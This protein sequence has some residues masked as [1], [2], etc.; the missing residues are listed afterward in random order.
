MQ[1]KTQDTE[2]L[3]L[4]PTFHS[5]MQILPDVL[6]NV[7]T[8]KHSGN[9][10]KIQHQCHQSTGW[11][12][13]RIGWPFPTCHAT[14]RQGML[15]LT[16]SSESFS[17]GNLGKSLQREFLQSY[18]DL[19]FGLLWTCFCLFP[20]SGNTGNLPGFWNRPINWQCL[21][22]CVGSLV[23][24]QRPLSSDW[25]HDFL[26]ICLKKRIGNRKQMKEGTI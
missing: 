11:T 22:K 3:N 21:W 26:N 15:P 9:T 12:W 24:A 1:N 18:F 23:N 20:V 6:P 19:S 17:N 14:P 13:V 4:I 25:T 10:Q 7:N 16:C 2:P 5:F 8:S